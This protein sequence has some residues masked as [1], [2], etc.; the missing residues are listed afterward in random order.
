MNYCRFPID[1]TLR[2]F[3]LNHTYLIQGRPYVFVRA[4]PT[5]H[6]FISIKTGKGYFKRL[7]YIN[8][9]RENNFLIPTFYSNFIYEYR[10]D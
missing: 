5:G 7:L 3:K 1:F 2:T 10:I 6:N 4:T 9:K 8:K